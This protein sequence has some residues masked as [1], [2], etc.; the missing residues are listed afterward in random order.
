MKHPLQWCITLVSYT[1]CLSHVSFI[2][3]IGRD[4]DHLGMVTL[5]RKDLLGPNDGICRAS[6][7]RRTYIVTIL[8]QGAILLALVDVDF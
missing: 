3:H 5:R 8:A 4:D 1:N 6:F 2:C 7:I